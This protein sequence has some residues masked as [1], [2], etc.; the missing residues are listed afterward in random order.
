[1]N[2]KIPESR[3]EEKL[4]RCSKDQAPTDPLINTANR[5]VLCA[6]RVHGFHVHF[7]RDQLYTDSESQ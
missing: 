1:M 3:V 4:A 2:E 7:E 5:R 6:A